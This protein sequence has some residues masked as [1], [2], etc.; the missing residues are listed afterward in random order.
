[1]AEARAAMDGGAS[2]TQAVKALRPPIFWREAD[3]VAAALPRWPQPRI[4]AGLAALLAGERAI[5]TAGGPGEAPGW[6]ALL[7]LAAEGGSRK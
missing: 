5:K 2:A 3:L 4:R 6:H 1:M 7:L